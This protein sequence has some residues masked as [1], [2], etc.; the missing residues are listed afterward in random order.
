MY[1]FNNI[2]LIVIVASAINMTA[3]KLQVSYLSILI[4]HEPFNFNCAINQK[5]NKLQKLRV[6]KHVKPNG[7]THLTHYFGPSGKTGQT[8]WVDPFNP[9][10]WR[11]G[12][13]FYAL[14]L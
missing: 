4:V 2:V 11:A 7:L 10:F 6:A 9:L 8:H 12:P 14:W 1:C 5:T 13:R 3:T